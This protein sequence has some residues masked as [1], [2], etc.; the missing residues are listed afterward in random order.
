MFRITNTDLVH[1]LVTGALDAEVDHSVGQ[2][3][4]HVEL[5]A[6]VVHA[7]GVLLVVMLL[8]ADPSGHQ[9]ILHR[10]GEREEVISENVYFVTFGCGVLIKRYTGVYSGN[11]LVIRLEGETK[12]KIICCSTL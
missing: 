9:V 4:A 3:P 2:A 12:D 6:E 8:G 10:V 1:G 7:L 5:Q 11:I